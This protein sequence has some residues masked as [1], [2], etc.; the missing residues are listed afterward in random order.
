MLR[1]EWRNSV[2]S[3]KS[4]DL[5]FVDET[6]ATIALTRRYARAP[7]GQR[8]TG[9][10]PRNYGKSTTM[11]AAL[12]LQGLGPVMTIEGAVDTIAFDVY[13]E[14]FLCPSLRAG[15][16]VVWDNL[17][18]HKAEVVRTRVEA[19]GCNVLFLP[20]YSPDLSPIELTFSK[21]K[22]G[23]RAIGARTQ[24]ELNEAI[25]TVINKVVASDAIGWFSHCGYPPPC[26]N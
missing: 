14:R 24:T 17:S 5:V 11:V 18:V 13:V 23:L 15:Q 2:A 8:A 16:V 4:E 1:Q 9:V 7:K 25:T 26:P 6:S 20:P 19:A 22:E 10:T 3:I 12:S 21:V